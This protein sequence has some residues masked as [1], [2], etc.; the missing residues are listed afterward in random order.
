MELDEAEQKLGVKLPLDLRCVYRIHNGQM[1]LHN[2]S[3]LVGYF[4]TFL[5]Y[6]QWCNRGGMQGNDVPPNIYLGERHSPSNVRKRGNGD[7]VAFHQIGHQM[8]DFKAT[9]HQI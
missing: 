1:K 6:S 9:M 5:S 7:T 8:L 2:M 3:S 4:E